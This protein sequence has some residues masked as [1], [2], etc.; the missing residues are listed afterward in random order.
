MHFD[1]A[2]RTLRELDAHPHRLHRRHHL[3]RNLGSECLGE[4][5]HIAEAPKVQLERLRL[6]A[7]LIRLVLDD[8]LGEV[9]LGRHR[10]D[11]G[12]FVRSEPH[13]RHVC[14][15]REDLDMVDGLADG[16]AEDGQIVE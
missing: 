4:D 10:A 6:D 15:R 5:R 12:E 3:A 7:E 14:W 2:T 11:R 9:R 8:H 16:R 1:A 13:R